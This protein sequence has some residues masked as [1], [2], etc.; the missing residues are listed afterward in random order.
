MYS[1]ITPLFDRVL[2][3]RVEPSNERTAS[4]LYIPD[5][6]QEKSQIG[7]V[8]AVGTGKVTSDG[9]V[10]PL[11]VKKGDKVVFAKYAGADIEKDMLIVR[12]EDILGIV[13]R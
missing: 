10:L 8:I 7:E 2:L 4:G 13:G 5:A 3:R 1:D 12:E 6:A 11:A 9:R